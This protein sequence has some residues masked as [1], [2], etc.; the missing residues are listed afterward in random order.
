MNTLFS[1]AMSAGLALAQQDAPVFTRAIPGPPIGQGNVMFVAQFSGGE[2]VKGVP[3][4]AD[5]VTETVH[6]LADG[7][8]I[9]HTNKS[10]FARDSEGRTR[11]ESTIQSLGPV[12]QTEEPIVSIFIDDPVAKVRYTLDS[13]TK[14]AFKSKSDSAVVAKIGAERRMLAQDNLVTHTRIAEGKQ[15]QI[16]Q[17]ER[18][19]E[20][21]SA[22]KMK[23]EEL[24]ARNIE[25][26]MAKGT[27]TTMVIPAGEVGNERAIEVVT[28][29]WY[30]DEIKTTVLTKQSDP[31]MGELTTKLINLSRSEPPKSLFEPPVEYRVEEANNMLQTFPEIR[32]IVV[33]EDR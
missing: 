1:I 20:S 12:G 6:L 24:G 27:R 17:V 18:R 25:G 9:K 5:T 16:V 26:V 14:T 8:R 13:R 19:I 2:N 11:R 7:N 32:R 29:T 31:R 23:K 15:E 33:K 22:G 30:S 4:S 21:R 10:S 3:Y 28:E